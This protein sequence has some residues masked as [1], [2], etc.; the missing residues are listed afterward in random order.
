MKGK[1]GRANGVAALPFQYRR[2]SDN[3]LPEER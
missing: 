3:G 1:G 2:K